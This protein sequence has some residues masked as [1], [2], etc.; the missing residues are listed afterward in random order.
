MRKLRIAI[1]DHAVESQMFNRRVAV[2]LCVVV[3]L[4]SV[5][6]ANL[7]HLQVTKYEEYSTRADGNR[8]KLMPLSPNRGMI[9]DRNGVLLAENRP[10]HTLEIV[11]E[12]VSDLAATVD[13]LAGI[14]SITPEQ[15][16]EF[17][18][19]AKA[20]RRFKSIELKEHLTEAEVARLAVHLHRFPGVTLEARLTRYYPYGDLLTHALG[21]IGKIN[22]KE[23]KQL[24]EQQISAN[25]AATRDIGK[26]GLEKFYE[27]QLHGSV[28]YQEV[29][30]NNRGRVIRTLQ[31]KPAISGDDLYLTL[32][33]GLQ[34]Q[35]QAAL[36]ENRG[37][38]VVMDPRDGSILAFYSNP[39]YNPNL[40][41]HGISGKDYRT[42]LNSP[43]TPLVNRITQGVYPPAST[44]KPLMAVL[45]LEE[46]VVTEQTRI[47]DPGFYRL[48]GVSRPWRD[49]QRWGHGYVDVYTGIIK[50]CDT[51][52]YDLAMKLGIDKIHPFMAAAGY[53]KDSGIDIHEETTALM[54]SKAW[55]KRRHKLSWWPGDTINVGIGQGYWAST[56]LQMVLTTATLLNDGAVVTP[57]LAHSLRNQQ[58]Q[59]SLLKDKEQKITVK[60]PNNWAIAREGMRRTVAQE[61]GTAKMAFLGAPYS[62]GGK[63]GTAQVI[64]IAQGQKYNANA[65][66]ERHRD[67]ALYIGYAPHENPEI[68]VAVV[69]ENAGGGGSNAAPVARQVMDYYFSDLMKNPQLPSKAEIEQMQLERAN[70]QAAREL[71]Y[72]AEAEA[73]KAAAAARKK[74]K[75]Q[76]ATTTSHERAQVDSP[77]RSE[78]NSP[79][80]PPQST[81]EQVPENTQIR[82]PQ[83]SAENSQRQ[84]T[85]DA[86]QP[87]P[88]PAIGTLASTQS[89]ADE[90]REPKHET[91]EPATD[92]ATSAQ[93]TAA[94][95]NVFSLNTALQSKH[96]IISMAVGND[97]SKGVMTSAA[98]PFSAQIITALPTLHAAPVHNNSSR[99]I[100]GLTSTPRLQ[101]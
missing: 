11:P 35:A 59:Q 78:V 62:S 97:A 13:A 49:W 95:V 75:A 98:K 36:G 41:V 99:F 91:T 52:F 65:I 61:G 73:E 86:S 39:S 94:L 88:A 2:A 57:R 92:S 48:P 101:Q 23:Y 32:D 80:R 68:A 66:D 51:Y 6:I 69:V 8:I 60:N 30:V 55:K 20:Q 14:I 15:Q 27:Q 87:S 12:Q 5:L 25:Y 21:Y 63:T 37:A 58:Q 93:N 47:P 9:F 16:S 44:V 10:V 22:E 71:R 77:E 7:Y 54:P 56:P 82:E 46:G 79:E 81:I 74:L 53:G 43:D 83:N 45:G 89:A 70:A 3:L 84:P 4:F 18:A 72:Q 76:T 29:E 67:N 17:L 85:S 40:F 34:L 28:G 96:S 31:E 26:V 33:L 38:I 90:V 1:A 50:S 24:E 100:Q 19:R 64:A 42:L